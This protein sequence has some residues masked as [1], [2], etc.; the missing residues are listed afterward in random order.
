MSDVPWLSHHRLLP[1][2]VLPGSAYICLA[3][4]AVSQYVESSGTGLPQFPVFQLRNIQIKAALVIPENEFGIEVLTGI[5]VSTWSSN[6]FEFKVTSLDSSGTWAENATGLISILTSPARHSG[7]LTRL[8]DRMDQRY[9]DAQ[10]WYGKFEELG[11]GYGPSFQGLSD[12]LSDPFRNIASGKVQLNTT[13]GM[14]TGPESRYVI[15]PATLDMCFQA[16]LI[17]THGGQ[18]AKAQTAYVPSTIEEITVWPGVH[19]VVTGE[20]VAVSEKRG[21][22][23][24]LSQVQIWDQSGLPR[25]DLRHLRSVSY[26]GGDYRGDARPCNEY[27]RLVWKPDISRLSGAQAKSI[28]ESMSCHNDPDHLAVLIDLMGHRDPDMKIIQVGIDTEI[29]TLVLR[30]L[31]GHT[32]TMRYNTFTI[33]TNAIGDP[34]KDAADLSSFKGVV[35]RNIDVEVADASRD[36]KDGYDLI[37]AVNGLDDA[38]HTPTM[39]R[40]LRNLAKISGKLVLLDSD[41]GRGL[42][43]DSD[44]RVNAFSGID[45][46]LHHGNPPRSVLISTAIPTV[47]MTTPHSQQWIYIIYQSDM[48]DFQE[49]LA[50]ES[51]NK[52]MLPLITSLATVKDIPLGSRLVMAIDLESGGLL[53][54]SAEEYHMI[55]SLTRIAS[56]MLWLTKGDVIAKSEPRAAIATGL[57][58]ML[59]TEKPESHFGVLHLEETSTQEKSEDAVKVVVERETLLHEGD[60]ELE[61]A[62]HLGVEYIPRLVYDSGLSYRHQRANPSTPL[63]VDALISSQGPA[64]LDFAIPGLLSSAYFK[65][66]TSIRNP[67]LDDWIEI[68]TAAISLNW[69]DLSMASGR[70]TSRMDWNAFNC[71]CSGTVVACGTSVTALQPGDRVYALAWSWFGTHIRIPAILAQKMAPNET[72]EQMSTLP[73]AF[74][75]AVYG[76]VHL[77]RLKRGQRV[78]I[79]TAT[80]GFGLAALQV[81]MAYEATVYATVGTLEKRA[82][83]HEHWGIPEDRI[84][85]SR[86]EAATDLMMTA[87]GERGFD[88]ILSTST[89]DILHAT[90]RCIA[91][92]GCFIDVG[93]LDVIH[94]STLALDVFER[95]ATFSSFDMS[96]LTRQDPDF[97]AELM[98]EVHSMLRA[99]MIRPIDAIQAF[100]VSKLDSALLALSKRAH[101]GKFVVS[102]ENPASLVKMIAPVPRASFDSNA[103]YVVVGGLGGF[104]RSILRWLVARGARHLTIFRRHATLDRE[105]QILIDDLASEGATVSI[106]QVDVTERAKV[107]KALDEVSR[108]HPVKG[109][110]HTAMD[111]ADTTFERL[112][113]DVWKSSLSCKVQGTFNLHEASLA[114]RLPLDFF[115]LVGSVMSL[116]AIPAHVGYCTANAFQDAFSRYRRSLGLP[117]CTIGFGLITEITAVARRDATL[118]VNKRNHLYSTGELETL[119]LLE[120]A[121]LEC[122]SEV[123]GNHGWQG[124]DPLAAAQYTAYWDP[125][126]LANVHL[127][128]QTPVWYGNRKYSHVLRALQHRLSASDQPPQPEVDKRGI[129]DDVDAA[130]ENETREQAVHIVVTAIR[131]RLSELLEIDSESI[132][133]DASVA[134]Y[135]LDSL[136]AVELRGWFMAA[137]RKTFPL[138]KLLDE[139]VSIRNLAGD[140]VDERA[141][142]IVQ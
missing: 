107:E 104:G 105:A 128:R 28:L 100:D 81:A 125:Y 89:S 29:S 93:R 101:I 140:I 55:K 58:R 39:S 94:H 68:K 103:E 72:F 137:F 87:T 61:C 17:A 120:A 116:M 77:G 127:D 52:G 22:R 64:V 12:L 40:K 121:F 76:L 20:I 82:Y 135:G 70:V 96:V 66:N 90:W 27:T 67:L 86:E 18:T 4:E 138:L 124:F 108:N 83:L 114:L 25:V 2:L 26:Y 141:Q 142:A 16:A 139:R 84:F 78:L 45:I 36:L 109:I 44:L 136:I 74:C 47:Y 23:H 35:F 3:I 57:M 46:A 95:N 129:A 21:I 131:Q 31:G 130:I 88:I 98:K 8:N 32:D 48:T 30:T 97:V 92:R 112:E 38:S 15:H 126:K 34:Y 118:N 50:A 42:E 10:K 1:N 62:L 110:L 69:K 33:A 24:T 113:Y 13:A 73:L 54:V 99:G 102:C 111:P 106:K 75:T 119:Q 49:A 132:D 11:L 51:R 134:E 60:W 123:D 59:T 65:P 63:I 71:E 37:I 56:S 7:G 53:D 122:P 133:A 5:N 117:S 6:W 79:Q 14:F 41:P 43:W 19:D 80:G 91:P 115:V 9:I 85:S